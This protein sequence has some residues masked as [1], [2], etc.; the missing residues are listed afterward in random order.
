MGHEGELEDG[1]WAGVEGG[2]PA[3][4]RRVGVVEAQCIREE[5]SAEEVHA[6]HVEA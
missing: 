1:G 6:S 3:G 5:A 4:S 2:A